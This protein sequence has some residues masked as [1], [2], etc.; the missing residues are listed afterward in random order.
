MSCRSILVVEDDDDIRE[1][2]VQALELEGYNVLQANNG[3]KALDVLLKC[4]R[5]ELPEC[6]LLDLMMPEMNG[7]SLMETIEREYKDRLGEI[8]VLVAT[9]KGSHVNPATIPQAVRRLQKPFDLEELYD[10]VQDA[11]EKAS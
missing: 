5:E 11:C 10:A 7:Q 3:R 8:R 4:N 1:Q 6:M 2:V 9:A